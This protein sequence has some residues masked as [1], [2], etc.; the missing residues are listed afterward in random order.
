VIGPDSAPVPI[1]SAGPPTKDTVPAN[2]PSANPPSANPPSANPPTAKPPT[3][4]PPTAKPPT[5]NPP[6]ANPQAAANPTALAPPPGRARA[7]GRSDT[8]VVAKPVMPRAIPITEAVI[9]LQ[10]PL[11]PKLAYRVRATG[12]R[13]LLGRTGDSERGYTPPA[14]PPP[15]AP[16]DKPGAVPPASKPPVKK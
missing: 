15:I 4:N 11:T 5:A 8:L 12:I 13:G 7:L 16:A 10:R 2:P 3:A 6:T 1:V 9:K 14:P